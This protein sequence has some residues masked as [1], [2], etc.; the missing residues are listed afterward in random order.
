MFFSWRFAN[1]GM[2]VREGRHGAAGV[3]LQADRHRELLKQFTQ[4]ST[5]MAE[6]I[7]GEE[8]KEN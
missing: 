4:T 1:C 2:S 8:T 3:G 7:A 6:R 5:P